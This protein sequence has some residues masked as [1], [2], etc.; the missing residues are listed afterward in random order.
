MERSDSTKNVFRSIACLIFL[1]TTILVSVI[2]INFA[3]KS[4]N[5]ALINVLH[6][7]A[8]IKN[9]E[10]FINPG[11]N[12]ITSKVILY[13]STPVIFLCLLLI[14]LLLFKRSYIEYDKKAKRA[15]ILNHISDFLHNFV[16][17]VFHFKSMAIF[18]AKNL[19]AR[20]S[21]YINEMRDAE[22]LESEVVVD[23]QFVMLAIKHACR[24]T[25]FALFIYL[26]YVIFGIFFIID[27]GKF[28]A[29]I[30]NFS[31]IENIA[32]ILSILA[33][34]GMFFSKDI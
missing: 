22:N 28:I 29:N 34:F 17:I 6:I 14:C 11:I 20:I 10:V 18:E 7:P 5:I 4:K 30:T 2:G 32:F 19:L 21:D 33:V 3:L 12:N 1:I 16:Y 27:T 23:K 31:I 15:N 9:G 24:T 13:Y 8:T 26:L 25:L